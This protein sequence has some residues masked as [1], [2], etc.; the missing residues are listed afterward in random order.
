[1][2]K[3]IMAS[4]AWVIGVTAFVMGAPNESQTTIKGRFYFDYSYTFTDEGPK[5]TNFLS[6]GFMFRR[7]YLTINRM[8][9]ETFS[10]RFRTDIDRK[11]DDKLRPFIKNLYIEWANLVPQSKLY[12]GMSNTPIKEIA[13]EYWGYRA[14]IKSM[15]D[16]YKTAVV[17]GD[18]DANTADLG[19]ALKGSLG[20]NYGYHAMISNG[21]GYSKPEKDTYRKLSLSIHTTQIKN[22]MI[23]LYGDYEPQAKD[24]TAVMGKLFLGYQV[25]GLIVGIEYGLRSEDGSATTQRSGLSLFSRYMFKSNFGAYA[26]YDYLEPNYDLTD[27]TVTLIIIGLDYLPYKTFNILPNLFIYTHNNSRKNNRTVMGR[28]TFQVKF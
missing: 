19:F 4:L 9:N 11:A 18:M 25:S 15:T 1:M 21:S 12:I 23:E 26:R 16:L 14:V 17:T 28:L 10:V 20:K 8:L 3:K 24:S 27:D 22:L 7:G 13:E 2:V 5:Y 6:D